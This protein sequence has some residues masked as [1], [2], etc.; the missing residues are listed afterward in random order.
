MGPLAL[1]LTACGGLAAPTPSAYAD[2]L[3]KF[4]GYTLPGSLGEPVKPAE[5]K[6]VVRE[7]KTGLG[8]TILYSVYDR[9]DGRPGDLWNTGVKGLEDSFVPGKDSNGQVGARKLDT[10]AR[11]LYLYQVIHDSGRDSVVKSA[12]VRLLVDPQ[13]IKSWGYFGKKGEAGRGRQPGV[14]IGFAQDFRRSEDQ[15]GRGRRT[16]DLD[17]ASGGDGSQVQRS[18]AVLP[19][20]EALPHRPHRGG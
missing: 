1:L 17:R 18:V 9:A 2:G 7:E 19:G 14:G 13:L 15:Q 10:N 3:P 11:Y 12:T 16:A 20:E 5:G 4:T 8:V 6:P